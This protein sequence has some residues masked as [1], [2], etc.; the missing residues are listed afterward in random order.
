[1]KSSDSMSPAGAALAGA[2]LADPAGPADALVVPAG[3]DVDPEPLLHAA[4]AAL[5]PTSPAAA[6][7]LRRL[8]GRRID[9]ASTWF[10]SRSATFDSSYAKPVPGFLH[11]TSPGED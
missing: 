8:T 7:K 2:A 1:M 3:D 6:R 9:C 5:P 10:R 11:P 4:S